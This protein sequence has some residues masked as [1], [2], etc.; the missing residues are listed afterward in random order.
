MDL[1]ALPTPSALVDLD[2]VE[3]NTLRMA[4]RAHALSVRLRPHV[5]TH[6]CIEAARLQVRGHFGGIT[7]STLAE[8]RAFA[9][10]G[11][12]DILYAV[13]PAPQRASDLAA[14]ARSVAH[15]AVVTDHPDAV[16][17]LEKAAAR[18]GSRLGV[19]VKI[20]C[21]LNRAGIA[22]AHH[23]VLPLVTV[24]L[25]SR[26]L[27]FRGLLT[28][29]GQAYHGR[30]WDAVR[31]VA[32]RERDV[33]V[34]LAERLRQEGVDV[35]EV[36]VGSTP[37]ALAADNLGGVTEIRPGNYVFFDAF[38]RDLGCCTLA[39]CAFTVLATVIGRYPERSTVLLD[40][41]AL[42]LSKDEGARHIR[43]HASYGI[44]LDAGGTPI[45]YLRLVAL[46]QEHGVVRLGRGAP[47]AA[48]PLGT[49]V[50]IVPNHSCLAA[51]MFDRFH[52]VQGRAVVDQWQPVRG[53]A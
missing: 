3:R 53:W 45:P 35:P 32:R 7:V 31:E 52:V 1:D 44:V 33:V 41:G 50:R 46:T 17:V 11:F 23:A 24:I 18:A 22:P 36:S 9:A 21:G 34:T 47:W 40:A 16:E 42:A 26:H 10:A 29:A 20:D 30:N 8:A 28:H 5:K 14:L 4:A 39:D 15:L 25:R 19:F 27:R 43:R 2:R 49:R 13:P 38:Q 37:T 12:A 48:L 6:K 51:A